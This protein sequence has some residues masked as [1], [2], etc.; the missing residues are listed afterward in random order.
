MTSVYINYAIP[1]F[2]VCYGVPISGRKRRGVEGQR[3]VYLNAESI[4]AFIMDC[5]QERIDFKASKG[6]DDIW[7]EIDL[8]NEMREA[9]ALREI[10][11]HLGARYR[12]LLNAEWRFP[13]I[14]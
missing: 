1:H 13:R 12:P 11:A 8:G 5:A 4:N 14:P 2:S 6:F 10:Q 9:D 7:I 3:V